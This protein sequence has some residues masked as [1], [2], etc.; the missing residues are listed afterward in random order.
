MFTVVPVVLTTQFCRLGI[1]SAMATGN[2]HDIPYVFIAFRSTVS[3]TF[4]MKTFRYFVIFFL[5]WGVI[6]DEF[7]RFEERDK[8]ISRFDKMTGCTYVT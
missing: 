8:I 6:L 3:I 7:I 4:S 1:F 2:A 5:S